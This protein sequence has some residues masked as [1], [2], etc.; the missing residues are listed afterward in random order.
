MV[1][2]FTKPG[3]QPCRATIR[4]LN[5]LGVTY[6]RVDITQ[7]ETGRERIADLGYSQAPVVL[8]DDDIHWS[9]YKPDRCNQ[10]AAD[11]QDS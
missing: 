2:V 3:C 1:T 11:V 5:Q 4:K 8:V 7:D 6:H 10:L 9:G